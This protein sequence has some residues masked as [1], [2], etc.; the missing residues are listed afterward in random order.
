MSP[1][2]HRAVAILADA[3]GRSP[4]KVDAEWTWGS[5]LVV[6]T[7]IDD[8]LTIFIKAAADQDV[9]TEAAAIALARSAGVP[10]VD[11]LAT[12]T[13]KQ[14]PGGRWIIT[15]SASGEP[16]QDV[17]RTAPTT[18][19]TLDDLAECYTRLHQVT[20]PG[21]GPLG[22]GGTHA[23][24]A[25]WSEWQQRIIER[26][27]DQLAANGAAS[28]HFL[29]RSHHLCEKFATDLDAA[30]AALLHADLGDRELFVD[31]G[32]GDVTSIVDWGDALIGD[33]LYDLVR[34]VGGGPAD[35]PRPAQLHPTLHAC[36]L[37]RNPQ[38]RARAR[39]MMTFYRF[40]ICV[41][42]AAWEP[43]WAPAHIAWA[44]QLI[45]DLS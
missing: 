39:R 37:R 42:E 18:S 21:H 35:D 15:R 6:R 27:L 11:V 2:H 24:F 7:V 14:L 9:H 28:D 13:D 26:A 38:H 4:V 22:P 8:E 44:N 36:Y 31:P 30:P 5:T 1:A 34:F 32:T 43:D 40:H 25:T 17:G 19:Q 29:A 45:D 33:P 41:V 23:V 3:V 16:M 12:G 10:T 20:L